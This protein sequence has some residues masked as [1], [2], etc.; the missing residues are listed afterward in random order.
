MEGAKFGKLREAKECQFEKIEDLTLETETGDSENYFCR[1]S[2]YLFLHENITSVS[3]LS[4]PAFPI[5]TQCFFRK[6]VS[7]RF[8]SDA[9][10]LSLYNL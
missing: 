9:L 4:V 3:A 10:K 6:L 1:I 5:P 7:V 8:R 2:I